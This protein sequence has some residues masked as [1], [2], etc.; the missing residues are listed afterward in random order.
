MPS[1]LCVGACG[2]G[3]RVL[4]VEDNPDGRESLRLLLSLLGHRVE[5]AAT[6]PDGVR[7]ALQVRPNVALIDLSLPGMD[8]LQ[9]ARWLRATLG[10]SVVLIAY[11]ADDDPAT[12]Q[13]VAEAGYDAHVVK[14]AR[15]RDLE[16]WLEWSPAGDVTPKTGRA[17]RPM[18]P[19]G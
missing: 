19:S 15:L 7:K 6:G 18:R 10:A 16:P 3:R 13:A 9:V 2:T 8:G 5:V 17:G 12:T 14:P 11:T 1:G 4:L